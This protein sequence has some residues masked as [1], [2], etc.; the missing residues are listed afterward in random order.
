MFKHIQ[1]FP[2]LFGIIVGIFAILYIKPELNI[3]YKYP[4]PEGEEQHTYKDKNGL[5]YS[6][7]SSVV[8]CDKNES[9]IKPFP[10]SK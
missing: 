1:L 3:I 9:R 10:L 5:C 4:N 6:Y 7:S 2:L 8:D